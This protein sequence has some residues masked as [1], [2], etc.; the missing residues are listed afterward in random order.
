MISREELVEK[1]SESIK[2]VAPW[3]KIILFG[4]Q[5]R[6]EA[7]E[8]SDIDLLILVPNE[9]C[10]QFNSIKSEIADLLYLLELESEILISPLI[11]LQ[12]MWNNITTPFSLNVEKDGIIL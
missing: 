2:K 9:Y 8:S 11:L 7:K 1:A 10:N 4:S 6:G 12:K 3:A 5:A